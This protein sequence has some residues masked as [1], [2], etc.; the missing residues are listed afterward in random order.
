MTD[1]HILVI[2]I[3]IVAAMIGYVALVERVR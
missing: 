2:L 1:F 3:L